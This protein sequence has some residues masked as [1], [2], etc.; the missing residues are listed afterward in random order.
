MLQV[1]DST[2]VLAAVM[3]VSLSQLNGTTRFSKKSYK[4]FRNVLGRMGMSLHKLH[5]FSFLQT[6]FVTLLLKNDRWNVRGCCKD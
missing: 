3:Y 2:F 5:K 4:Q 1:I 6:R